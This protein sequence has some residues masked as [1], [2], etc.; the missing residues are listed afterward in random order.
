MY[1]DFVLVGPEDDPAKAR[2]AG[3]IAE[4]FTQIAEAG[5][6]FIS[7]GDESGTHQKE[8]QIWKAASMEPQG[9]WHVQAGAGM[10]MVLRM[11]DQKD[12]YT[13]TDR[14]TFLAQRGQFKLAVVFE[15]DEMLKN[16][17]AVIVVS[18][19]KHPHAKADAARQFVKFLLAPQTQQRIAT[20]G[21]EEYGQPLFFVFET[22]R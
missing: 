1:N 22:E 6:T 3:S 15:G 5:A 21:V 2:G 8:R 9:E 18:K 7:R 19:A 10:A 12:A 13:L 14:A 11:A 4:A 20:F 17:Y 16:P